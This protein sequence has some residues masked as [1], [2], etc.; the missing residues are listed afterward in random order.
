MKL[1]IVTPTA[2]HTYT[3]DWVE[4]NTLDGNRIIQPGHAPAVFVL[5][6]NYDLLFKTS[7]DGEQ[8]FPISHGGI[9]EVTRLETTVIV[10]QR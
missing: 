3:I 7:A 9:V 5:A 4:L 10:Q 2:S 1:R 6:P 8:I